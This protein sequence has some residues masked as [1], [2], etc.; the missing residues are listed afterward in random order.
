VSWTVTDAQSE[1]SSTTGCDSATVMVDTAGTTFTCSATSAGG[2]ASKSVTVKRDTV[3]PTL[4]PTAT[5][6]TVA[7]GGT[8]TASA[9]ATDALS[10]IASQSCAAVSTATAGTISVPCTATDKAGNTATAQAT[11]TVT[12]PTTTGPTLTYPAWVKLKVG[13]WTRILPKVTG[14]TPA[15]YVI[16]SGRLPLGL[17]LDTATGAVKGTPLAQ[18]GPWYATI[19]V[20]R[21]SGVV[22]AVDRVKFTATG[23]YLVRFAPG[24]SSLTST[25]K[26]TLRLAAKAVTA[27]PGRS[28]EVRG[29]A[30]Y[31]NG[32]LEAAKV[33][34]S[35]RAASV[36]RYL[37]ELGVGQRISVSIGVGYATDSG[38]LAAQ[39]KAT[40]KLVLPTT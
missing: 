31:I 27:G 11:V 3:K 30:A 9:N 18:G 40:V 16:V 24:S 37:R 20:K 36:K 1:V 32:D 6:S 26:A 23:G 34:A 4:S 2:T 10:G 7:V 15:S 28:L 5:P 35:A 17:R 22:A 29:Y 14:M 38:T 8:S 12:A 13:T 19:G 21:A 39:R 33:I 25:A